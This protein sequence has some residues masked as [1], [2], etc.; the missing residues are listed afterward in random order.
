MKV[1]EKLYSK[2]EHLANKYANKLFNYANLSF[3]YEDLL[4]EFRIKIYTSIKAYGR[5][6]AKY[7]N[8]EAP[9][10]VPLNYYLECACSNKARDFMKYIAKES[11][12]TSIDEIDF[13]FGVEDN[14]CEISLEKNKFIVNNVDLLEGLAGND[15]VVFNLYLRGYQNN[16]I[17]KVYSNKE[18]KKK[19][20]KEVLLIID[21]QRERL[22][23][24]YGNELRSSRQMYVSYN[25]DEE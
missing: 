10:P 17:A 1:S 4:Q 23:K 7:E 9:E 20:I 8:G 11:V 18:Q 24:K 21:S 3:E 12:K 13:D 22:I 14:G 6:W 16:K 25:L 5:R 2:Y 15:R 19:N